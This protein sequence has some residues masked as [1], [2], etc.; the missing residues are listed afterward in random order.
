M[1]KRA[2]GHS[3]VYILNFPD[4]IL[5]DLDHIAIDL[6]KSDK[7]IKRNKLIIRATREF[8]ERR[9]LNDRLSCSP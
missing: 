2:Q 1:D 3:P 5:D 7:K 6:R 4:P 8:I 9:K